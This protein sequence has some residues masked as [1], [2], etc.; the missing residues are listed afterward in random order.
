VGACTSVFSSTEQIALFRLST[1]EELRSLV[2]KYCRALD[3]H[4]WA[5]LDSVFWKDS[6]LDYGEIYKG[7][8][9][10]FVD[11]VPGLLRKF[12]RHVHTVANALFHVDEESAQSETYYRAYVQ[13]FPPTTQIV[14]S[15]R[16]LDRFERRDNVWKI[17]ARVVTV[18]FAESNAA[19]EEARAQLNAFGTPGR[20][21]R[22]DA[23]FIAL[24]GLASINAR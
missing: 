1:T 5:I 6:I 13:T 17:A 12:E 9:P 4:D 18:D 8:F 3:R 21:D 24:P 10:G 7:T 15:G 19:N 23:S 16:Y 22:A 20:F 2:M 14:H 11:L